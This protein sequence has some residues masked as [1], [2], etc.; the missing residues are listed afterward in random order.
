[1]VSGGVHPKGGLMDGGNTMLRQQ[2]QPSEISQT[3]LGRLLDP[4]RYGYV[5]NGQFYRPT[6]REL[7]AEFF[8][9]LNVRASA[10]N[11]LCLL[12]WAMPL[13]LSVPLYL[14]LTRY[15][16]WRL[17]CL[18][19]VYGMVI[20]GS[21]G[22]FWLHR[23]STHRAFRFRNSFWRELLR[24]MVIRTVPEETYCL[25]HHV[26]HQFS[27]LPGDPYNVHGGWLYCFLADVVHQRLNPHL[28][29]V[30]Y[31][32]AAK[33]I[34]HTG[35]PQNT[36]AQYQRWGTVS[37]PGPTLL[38]FALNWAFWYAIFF[39]LGGHALALTLFGWAGIWAIGVRSF[40]YEGHGKGQDRRRPEVDF[41]DKDLSINQLWPGLVAGEWHNNHHLYPNGARSGFLLTQVDL[42]WYAIYGLHRLGVI[43]Q[44]RDY[45]AEFMRLHYPRRARLREA[46]IKPSLVVEKFT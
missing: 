16:D 15:F 44:F 9:H 26:H 29:E 35:V 41:N 13:L 34:G 12:G 42:P 1:M 19:F 28:S 14:S 27:E 36:Y 21:H 18:G 38:H 43:T 4:P 25:S 20:L 7:L 37:A 2:T 8:S 46:G 24:Q 31:G 32:R 11:W 45:R 3:I 33:L 23:Y 30:D 17:Q 22:T 6:R 10:K 39:G 5:R 40:N